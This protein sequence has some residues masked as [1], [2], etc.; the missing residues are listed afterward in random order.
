MR[1][2]LIVF[3]EQLTCFLLAQSLPSVIPFLPVLHGDI[4][5]SLSLCVFVSFSGCPSLSL[6]ICLSVSFLL[7]FSL[8]ASEISALSCYQPSQRVTAN[9]SWPSCSMTQRCK[10]PPGVTSGRFSPSH[11]LHAFLGLSVSLLVSLLKKTRFVIIGI[12]TRLNKRN[13]HSL[14]QGLFKMDYF[15][16]HSRKFLMLGTLTKPQIVQYPPKKIKFQSWRL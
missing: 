1:S 13:S 12:I 9:C 8:V 6:S 11:R 16:F 2:L 7:T 14:L 5:L 10:Q 4:C 15:A 3:S